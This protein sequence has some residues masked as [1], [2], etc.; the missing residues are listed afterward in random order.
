MGRHRTHW[1]RYWRPGGPRWSDPYYAEWG[2]VV[3][4]RVRRLRQDRDWRLQDLAFQVEKPEGGCYS[5]GYF[6]RLERGWT[7][8]PLLVYLRIAEAFEV[9]PGKLLGPDD[10]QREVSAEESV[11]L[12]FLAGSGIPPGE[13]I[14][15]LAA[16]PAE[17]RV[18]VGRIDDRP[19]TASS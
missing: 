5:A 8:A 12:D 18:D 2:V 13:A 11:L 4:D 16:Q 7:S 10:V 9:E 15:R 3:G 1:Q 6:S 19:A 14:A 17:G